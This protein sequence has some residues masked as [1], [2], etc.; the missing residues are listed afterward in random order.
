MM[1]GPF[2]SAFDCWRKSNFRRL[3]QQIAKGLLQGLCEF[4]DI[5]ASAC[6][7][8]DRD[9]AISQQLFIGPQNPSHP[10]VLNLQRDGS[11]LEDG[12]AQTPL[13]AARDLSGSP[14]QF[15]SRCAG[16]ARISKSRS[17]LIP[18]RRSRS[19]QASVDPDV[20]QTGLKHLG[21]PAIGLE[22]ATRSCQQGAV[23]NHRVGQFRP[24]MEN[25]PAAR[26]PTN[27]RNALGRAG[28]GVERRLRILVP[29]DRRGGR[30]PAIETN[31]K[32][33]IRGR[34][35]D[36]EPSAVLRHIV[37]AVRRILDG[38]T[39]GWNGTRIHYSN[40]EGLRRK[41]LLLQ[42]LRFLQGTTGHSGAAA[43]SRESIG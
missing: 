35:R 37:D 7:F 15:V 11:V 17:G 39:W 23:R 5:H 41:P 12:A 21:D 8:V 16:K 26:G 13:S 31:V 24:V 14:Q 4:R 38:N 36:L 6:C 10:P 32:Q 28:F 19:F 27:D 29:A 43:P 33:R 3:P 22:N 18:Q 34:L 20:A 2:S 1:V 42:R 25:S 9:H 40:P 30:V